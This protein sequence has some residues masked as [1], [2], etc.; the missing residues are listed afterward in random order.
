MNLYGIEIVNSRN[1]VVIWVEFE[2]NLYGIEIHNFE[3]QKTRQ[4]QFELNLYG[5]EI[6]FVYI[7][8]LS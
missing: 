5:I 1:Q 2:L 8:Y 6:T 3:Q 7:L 4:Y